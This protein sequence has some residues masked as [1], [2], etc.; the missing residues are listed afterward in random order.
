MQEHLNALFEDRSVRCEGI[1]V[2]KMTLDQA[3]WGY[4]FMLKLIA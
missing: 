3:R 1:V 2:R 4:L